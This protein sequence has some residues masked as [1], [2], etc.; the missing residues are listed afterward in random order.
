[1]KR[2]LFITNYASPYKVEFYDELSRH[3]DVTV[4]FSDKME[5]QKHRTKEWFTLGNGGF[6]SVQ[7]T[8]YAGTFLGENLC[9]DVIDWL[10]KPFDA[11]VVCGYSSPTAMLAIFWLKLMGKPFYIQADGGL[12]RETSGPRYWLK[13]ILVSQASGWISSGKQTTKYLMHY[14]AREKGMHLYPF[15]SLWEK[16]ISETIPDE[17]EKNQLRQK[18]NMPEKKIVLYVGRYDPKKGMEDLLHTSPEIDADAGIYFVGG[19]P[20]EAHKA[21]CEEK[22]LKNVHFV[23][24][25]KKEDLNQYYRAADLL[26]LPTWSD[27]WGL[28]INE[29]MAQGLPVVTTDQCVAGLELVEDNINGYIVPAKDTKALASAVNQVLS[30]DYRTMGETSLEKIR[31]YTLENMV[32]AYVD[33]LS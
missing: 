6:Q 4:L 31:P 26:V 19:E 14:G 20:T 27:V 30:A 25:R 33:I 22:N 3:L 1:M 7:L 11:F 21:F 2:V 32:K 16:D 5:D 23:G 29:A 12:I 13:R 8:R 18:L 28:V 9:L 17:A 15:T 24:F 10:K